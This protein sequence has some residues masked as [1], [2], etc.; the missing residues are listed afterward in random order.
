M[1]LTVNP[2]VVNAFLPLRSEV[3]RCVRLSYTTPYGLTD[4]ISPLL[5]P[6]AV[7]YARL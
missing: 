7:H 1:M 2:W 6:C 3:F 4:Y 5:P